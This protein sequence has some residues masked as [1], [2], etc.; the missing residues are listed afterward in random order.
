MLSVHNSATRKYTHTLE[1]IQPECDGAWVRGTTLVFAAVV[2]WMWFKQS[3]L[4]SH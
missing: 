4:D 3:T 2:L 1:L